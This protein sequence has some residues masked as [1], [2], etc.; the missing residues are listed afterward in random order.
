MKEHEFEAYCLYWIA[1]RTSILAVGQKISF[2]P[3]DDTSEKIGIIFRI[4]G[5]QK[6]ESIRVL[7]Y[8][9]NNLKIHEQLRIGGSAFFDVVWEDGTI[10][11]RIP[12][13]HLRDYAEVMFVPEIA[14]AEEIEQALK[15]SSL[16][17]CNNTPY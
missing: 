3:L 6:P 2:C 9:H 5:E 16:G 8:F 14:D 12:E 1:M 17:P 13:R 10:T 4:E 15:N 7:N 11:P